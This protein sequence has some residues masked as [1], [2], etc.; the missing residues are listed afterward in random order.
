[1]YIH[2]TWVLRPVEEGIQQCQIILSTYC[3]SASNPLSYSS[4]YTNL[5]QL[6]LAVNDFGY[7]F[8]L[9]SFTL[10]SILSD[11]PIYKTPFILFVIIYI[12]KLHSFYNEI[13]NVGFKLSLSL[14]L[15]FRS[16]RTEYF[17]SFKSRDSC[18]GRNST[19]R[20][21]SQIHRHLLLFQKAFQQKP[22]L[23]VRAWQLL[24]VQYVRH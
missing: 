15:S 20:Q 13:R 19:K 3:N 17:L 10:S 23:H 14:I 18:L 6:Y 16:I 22:I 7:T 8:N 24:I 1:M 4:K 12:P 9:C 11:M 21:Y 2:P 5:S